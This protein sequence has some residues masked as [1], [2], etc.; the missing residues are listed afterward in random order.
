MNTYLYRLC[1]NKTHLDISDEFINFDN[2]TNPHPNLR[3]FYPIKNILTSHNFLSNDRIGFFS[4][5]ITNKLFY[6]ISDINEMIHSSNDNFISLSPFFDE[7]TLYDNPIIQGEQYHPGLKVLTSFFL[8]E[9]DININIDNWIA[10]S[11]RSIYCNYFVATFDFWTLWLKYANIIFSNYK[12]AENTFYA[13][14]RSLSYS[15]FLCERL[16]SILF[17]S[18]CINAKYILDPSKTFFQNSVYYNM[19]NQLSTIDAIKC[20]FSQNKNY[21]YKD[22]LNYMKSTIL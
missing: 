13:G 1:W 22:A 5:N 6:S 16:V 14:G 3:E 4:P 18:Y 21:I 10:G 15:V 12:F 8:S 9:T 17:E 7:I 2:T 19:I 20:H 11:S